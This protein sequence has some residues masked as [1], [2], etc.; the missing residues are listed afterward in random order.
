[1]ERPP[2]SPDTELRSSE[3]SPDPRGASPDPGAPHLDY[4]RTVGKPC[5]DHE[6][7]VAEPLGT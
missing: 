4:Q 6:G 2:K 5:R 7:N 1:M 3:A